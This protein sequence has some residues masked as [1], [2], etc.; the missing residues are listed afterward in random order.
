MKHNQLSKDIPDGTKT[1]LTATV[2]SH[3]PAR[4]VS[5]G[6]VED[7]MISDASGNISLSV[8]LSGEK[9]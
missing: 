2:V 1:T 9:I 5:T 8:C 3:T 4:A 6:R 7:I